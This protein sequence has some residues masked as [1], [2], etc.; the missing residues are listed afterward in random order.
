ME[1]RKLKL[2][3]QVVVSLTIALLFH[4]FSSCSVQESNYYDLRIIN[5]GRATNPI[6]TSEVFFQEDSV[7]IY[8]AGIII[9]EER[10]NNFTADKE[11]GVIKFELNPGKYRFTGVGVHMKEILT[12]NVTLKQGDSLILMFYLP[13][14][15]EVLIH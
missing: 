11:T 15:D 14:S 5:S 3:L 2:A 13:Q 7:K 6:V 9:N 10:S 8:G 1:Q 12:E 4:T